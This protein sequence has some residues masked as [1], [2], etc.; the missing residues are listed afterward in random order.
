MSG[1]G[2]RLQVQHGHLCDD[3]GVGRDRHNIR[4][5]RVNRD[6]KRII[7]VGSG[8]FAPFDALRLVAD[9]GAS[10]LFLDGRGKLLFASTP[11][12]PSDVRL[13]RSQCL[14]WE[15]GAALNI[16]R[17]LISQKIDGQVGIVRDMLGNPVAAE[18]IL[19][20]KAELAEANDIDSVRLAESLA[21]KL[22]WSQ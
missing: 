7:V 18:A 11:T 14:A 6:L 8:G 9:V 10:L 21:E 2:L 22:Y 1:Y 17:E 13:R 5:S 4:L 3:W 20:F 16:S 15:N 19:R 12:A